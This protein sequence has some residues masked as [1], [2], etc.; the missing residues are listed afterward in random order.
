MTEELEEYTKDIHDV[1]N[2]A[3]QLLLQIRKNNNIRLIEEFNDIL[4]EIKDKIKCYDVEL[5]YIGKNSKTD[6]K[7][8]KWITELE[9]L[10]KQLAYLEKDHSY[11]DASNMS[12]D[13]ILDKC[14]SIQQEDIEIIKH[15]IDKTQD[16]KLIGRSTIN[17]HS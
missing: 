14:T 7:K 16:T 1:F 10:K 3:H 17:N 11:G 4:D 5:R 2:S 9:Q 12:T 15:M 6:I 13:Q 8:H